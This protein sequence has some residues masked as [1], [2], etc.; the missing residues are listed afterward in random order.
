M[1]DADGIV[2]TERLGEATIRL[3][4]NSF[5]TPVLFCEEDEEPI[6]G[7]VALMTSLL[8]V[9]EAKGILVPICARR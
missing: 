2:T 6:L 4:D 9:D 8:S 5:V 7:T 3:Q 1:V